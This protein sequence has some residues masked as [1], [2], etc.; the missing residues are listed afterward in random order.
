MKEE[1]SEIDNKAL[2][3]KEKDPGSF[4]LPC[5]INNMSFN[6]ALAELGASVSVM[7]LKTFATLGL[8]KLLPT[9]LLIELADKTVKRPEGIAE[10]VL[11]KIEKFVFPVDFNVL[12]MPEDIKIPLILGRSLLSS[13][14][15]KIDVFKKNLIKSRE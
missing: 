13:A 1:C 4:T 5:S 6:N 11:V 7:P 3:H 9:K 14:H 2:P 10:N 15:A 8:G 12:D